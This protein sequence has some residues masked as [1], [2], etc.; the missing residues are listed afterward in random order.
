MRDPSRDRTDELKADPESTYKNDFVRRTIPKKWVLRCLLADIVDL[1]LLALAAKC[2]SA[3][4]VHPR[5]KKTRTQTPEWGGT[6]S[7]TLFFLF[8]PLFLFKTGLFVSL[9]RLPDSRTQSG[10]L[11]TRRLSYT[12]DCGIMWYPI[13]L[14]I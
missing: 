3:I 12:S 11:G 7:T 10:S 14:Y 5:R 1:L 8:L 4:D 13:R 2:S 6:P 9:R